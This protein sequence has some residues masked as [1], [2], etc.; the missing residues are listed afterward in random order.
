APTSR[1]GTAI[2]TAMVATTIGAVAGPNLIEPLGGLAE[3]LGL[4]A[5]AGPFLLA[6]VAYLLAGTILVSLLRPDPYTVARQWE[7]Q[8][9][10]A[11]DQHSHDDGGAVRSARL[12]QVVE[13]VRVGWQIVM[14][15]VMTITPIHMRA[16]DHSMGA[17]RVVIGLPVG[18]MWL[19]SP[20][21]G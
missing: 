3:N 18:A 5:L 20:V 2:S 1:K 9:A 4:P 19:P 12:V 6:A 15:G 17:V 11:H 13:L 7:Q 16:H 8:Q 14:V 21:P 10:A